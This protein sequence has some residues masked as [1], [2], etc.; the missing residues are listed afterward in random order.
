MALLEEP[1]CR[2]EIIKDVTKEE[3]AAKVYSEYEGIKE[4]RS[5]SLD[6]LL[7]ELSIELEYSF[8][9]AIRRGATEETPPA[10]DEEGGGYPEE[11]NF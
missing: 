7:R 6:H 8:G 11:E 10:F 1:L 3:Y 9:E 4:F 2:V 5:R